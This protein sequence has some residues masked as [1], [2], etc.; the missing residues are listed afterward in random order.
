MLYFVFKL[1]RKLIEHRTILQKKV[2]LM[3]QIFSFCSSQNES[4][5]EK[6]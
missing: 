2:V 1:K 6:Q 5:Y 3:L 4:S